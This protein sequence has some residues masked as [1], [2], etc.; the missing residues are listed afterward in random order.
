MSET[1]PSLSLPYLMPSQAQKHVH[2]TYWMRW[3]S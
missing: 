3:F 2:W 1:S